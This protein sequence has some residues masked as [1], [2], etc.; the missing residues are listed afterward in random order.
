V[1][2]ADQPL[3]GVSIGFAGVGEMGSPMARNLLAAGCNLRVWNRTRARI[4]PLAALGAEAVSSP[5]ALG[6]A[7][8]VVTMVSD[9]PDVAAI[10]LGEDGILAGASEGSLW[11]DCSSIS[12]STAVSLA[13]HAR[14][15]G[16]EPVDAPVSGGTMGATEATLAIMVGASE[17]GFRRAEPVLR[18]LGSNVTHVGANGAGQVAKLVNQM[19]VGGTIALVSEGLALATA[20]G[21]SPAAVREALAGGFADSKIL[22]VHGQRMLDEAFAPG[23]RSSLQLK[24]LR[25]AAAEAADNGLPVPVTA[26]VEQLFAALVARGGGDLDHSG[27]A[28]LQRD[29]SGR[30]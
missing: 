6:E 11:I 26:L 13:E 21:C 8:V 30:A 28:V 20:A 27:L 12:P 1:T 23:F 18:V 17:E 22:Q 9:G 10:A 15:L 7:D 29:L 3:A 25:N 14:T 4:E 19:I 2:F 24:D 16:I 5:R